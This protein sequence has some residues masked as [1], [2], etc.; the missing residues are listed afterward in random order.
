[1]TILFYEDHEVW[2]GGMPSALRRMGHFVYVP[3]PGE[4]L[5]ELHQVLGHVRPDVVVTVGWSQRRIAPY[6]DAIR[7]YCAQ[8]RALHA[9]WSVE[10]PTHT[11]IWTLDYLEQAAPDA[12]FTIS[13]S[14]VELLRSLGFAAEHMPLAFDPL[15]HHPV[16]P[17][18]SWATD[19]AL[20]AT[21]YP[22]MGELRQR[23]L[24]DLLEG[25]IGG[26]WRVGI[27]GPEW[28][29]AEARIGLRLPDGWWRGPVA[30]ADLTAVYGSTGI[31]LS[32]QN[33]PELVASHTFEAL[34]CGALLL[35]ARTP[36]VA[37]L[38]TEGRHLLCTSGAAETRELVARYLG[39]PEA[40][41]AVRGAGHAEALA[42][43]TYFA[44]AAQLVAGAER[45]LPEKQ[46]W[47]YIR[48]DHPIRRQVLRP[49][50]ADG[51]VVDGGWLGGGPGGRLRLAFPEVPA[52]GAGERLVRAELA[53]FAE[54][55]EQAGDAACW[56]VGGDDSPQ[57]CVG[58]QHLEPRGLPGYPFAA[59]WLRWDVTDWVAPGHGLKVEV[60]GE[61]GLRA[62]WAAGGWQPA[63]QVMAMRRH[64]FLPRLTLVWSR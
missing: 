17:S 55:V 13:P 43:H 25:L 23:S 41:A 54:R 46:R 5:R 31:A 24:R 56:A 14:T 45:W 49:S 38:F 21:C 60:R 12:V 8:S 61:G 32:P 34:G 10:D 37:G 53:C 59:G 62:I 48:S 9:Y 19:V 30:H 64:R 3:H 15:V 39:D 16:E 7:A 6:V 42:R 26:A 4:G 50:P 29:K 28:D 33:E 22:P 52:A 44:R 2:V 18:P 51:A 11:E 57:A 1:V 47:G 27:W 36:G 20:V 35:T 58:R 40:A 63:L